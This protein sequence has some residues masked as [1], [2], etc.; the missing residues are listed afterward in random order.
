MYR[1]DE[2]ITVKL[3]YTTGSDRITST[4]LIEFIKFIFSCY[5]GERETG[6]KRLPPLPQFFLAHK[7]IIQSRDKHVERK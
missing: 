4:I 3:L 6:L 2:T 5:G 1:R 7:R